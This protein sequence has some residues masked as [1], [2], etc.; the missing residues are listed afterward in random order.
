MEAGLVRDVL[1][2]MVDRISENVRY[3]DE[4][5]LFEFDVESFNRLTST[6]QVTV[7]ERLARYL[8]Y[9]TSDT[10][11]LTAIN[12]AA[13]YAIF[14]TLAVEIEI[15]IDVED[16]TQ[17]AVYGPEWKVYW[18]SRTLSAYHECFADGLDEEHW[19]AGEIE[20]EWAVPRSAASQNLDQWV[21]MTEDLA[22]RILWDRDF[23]MAESFLD[24]APE[25]AAALK[26]AM[27]IESDY[28]I[29]VADD[30]TPSDI[31]VAL[32]RIRQITHQKPH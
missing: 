7:V 14:K 5:L 12:E 3:D 19:E 30:L 2:I 15:E 16:E 10:P 18:R 11:E 24:L 13:V 8:L 28:Y 27:G 29:S 6:E 1:A 21:S 22:D 4:D 25:K 26:H 31:Q 23:E 17:P 20:S 32:H 9:E